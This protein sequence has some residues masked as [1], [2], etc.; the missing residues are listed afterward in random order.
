MAVHR[1][2]PVSVRVP[3]DEV[4]VQSDGIFE[5]VLSHGML[6]VLNGAL[7]WELGTV[8]ADDREVGLVVLGH[9]STPTSSGARP[10]TANRRAGVDD[11]RPRHH[12]QPRGTIMVPLGYTVHEV[13]RWRE[14]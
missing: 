5:P 1:P 9:G 10:R 8:D 11:V 14:P 4:V 3:S 12:P 6:D 2:V 13:R 7:E